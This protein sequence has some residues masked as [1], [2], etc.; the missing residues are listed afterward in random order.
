[1]AKAQPKTS[2][3]GAP[4]GGLVQDQQ[5]GDAAAGQEHAGQAPAMAGAASE[6]AGAGDVLQG[7]SNPEPEA[8][9]DVRVLAAVT[10]AEQRFHPDDLIEGVPQ[11]VAQAYAGSVDPHPDA[12]AYARSIGAPVKPFP[13]QAHA[14]D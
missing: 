8:L 6:G 1:M 4:A 14:E 13:G 5:Q 11:G 2:A 9:V 3:D 10:I 12:V 7:G